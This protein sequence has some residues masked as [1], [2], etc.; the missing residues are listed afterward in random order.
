MLQDASDA[1][2]TRS[3]ITKAACFHFGPWWEEITCMANQD[4]DTRH[5]Q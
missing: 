2:I 3:W 1:N 4:L 5:K